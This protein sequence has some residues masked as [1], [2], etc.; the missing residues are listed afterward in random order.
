MICPDCRSAELA[1]VREN[2]RYDECGLA[3]I[4]LK[5]IQV[6]RCPECG[7]R[8][9]TIPKQTELHRLV[10]MTLVSKPG[11]LEASEIIYLRKSLG[12]SKTDF[13]A[14]V[15]VTRQQVSRWESPTN[16]KPMGTTH[17][18]LLRLLV[19]DNHEI[20]DYVEEMDKLDLKRQPHG[21][22]RISIEMVDKKWTAEE[23]ETA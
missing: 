5:N 4:T 14:K 13:A 19:A 18:L 16:P 2:I 6:E 20:R 17:E 11:R 8:L 12:W 23:A 15:H 22:R 10:A 21:H 1:E 9:V 3:Y 7:N